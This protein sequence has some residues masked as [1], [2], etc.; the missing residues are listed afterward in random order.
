MT[1]QCMRAVRSLLAGTALTGMVSL[2]GCSMMHSMTHWHHGTSAKAKPGNGTSA[3]TTP[4]AP[5][6]GAADSEV[7]STAGAAPAQS[8]T[9]TDSLEAPAEPDSDG[10]TSTTTTVVENVGPELKP[11]APKDYVV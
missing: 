5:G 10:G 9:V 3:P 1:S 2:G 8:R 6:S 4:E 7:A 11:S